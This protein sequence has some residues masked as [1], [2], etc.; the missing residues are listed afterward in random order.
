MN[1]DL[2]LRSATNRLVGYCSSA[3]FMLGSNMSDEIIISRKW[4]ERLMEQ[5]E[6]VNAALVDADKGGGK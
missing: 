4:L 1:N 3:G 6:E 2:K 5:A